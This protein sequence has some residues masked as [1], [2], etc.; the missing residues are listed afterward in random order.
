MRF[1]FIFVSFIFSFQAFSECKEEFFDFIKKGNAEKANHLLHTECRSISSPDEFGED[2]NIYQEFYKV[3]IPFLS[4]LN[5]CRKWSQ[6][7]TKHEHLNLKKCFNSKA[8]KLYKKRLGNPL[9]GL[10]KNW[11]EK[12]KVALKESQKKKND[13][14]KSSKN[15]AKK[16]KDKKLEYYVLTY[17]QVGDEKKVTKRCEKWSKLAHPKWADCQ[18]LQENDIRITFY[19]S[20]SKRMNTVWYYYFNKNECEKHLEKL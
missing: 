13:L 10:S 16:K 3:S 1:L 11:E 4:D 2:E 5:K 17:L 14:H 8:M 9:S 6:S 12:Y 18:K 19:C 20:M 15:E 7:N